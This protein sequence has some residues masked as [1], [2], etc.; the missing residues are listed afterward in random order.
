MELYQYAR[1][2][3]MEGKTVMY[4]HGFASSGQT[5]TVRT[6]KMLLPSV[7]VVAPD[8]PV[9]PY[10]A[11]DVLHALVEKEKPSLVIGTSMG[12]MYAE[13]LYGT[14]RILI[15]P[16]FDIARTMVSHFGLGR[17]DFFN[18]RLD[19]VQSLLVTKALV[20]AYREVSTR[21]FSSEGGRV[22]ALFGKNDTTVN[23]YDLTRQHYSNCLYFDGAHHLDDAA[24]LHS[25]LPVIQWIDDAQER[26]SKPS[27]L[28]CVDDVLRYRNSGECTN[29]MLRSIEALAP[30]VELQF[31][32]GTCDCS[33]DEA[34]AGKEWLQSNL[35]V[36]AWNRISIGTSKD[37]ILADYMIDAH[38]SEYCGE[39]FMGTLLHFG[40]GD[41]RDWPSVLDYYKKVL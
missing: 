33:W 29:A 18:P 13:Q 26:R 19:G 14:D 38:P 34:L 32:I 4:L 21:C 40:Q 1:P 3:L 36:L 17:R 22:Y 39:G 16:A 20:E 37:I 7:H 30:L 15:N 8:I 2:S 23:T 25:V 27:V 28:V 10:E 5:G 31:F 11:L 12:G 6:L 9:D 35:G 24:F 41:F